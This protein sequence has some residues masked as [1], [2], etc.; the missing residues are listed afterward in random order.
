MFQIED[1]F[2]QA[3]TIQL[4]FEFGIGRALLR[5]L[6]QILKSVDPCL[7]LC[8]SRFG[9]L[10]HP[11]QFAFVEFQLL[12]IHFLLDGFTFTLLE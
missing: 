11:L 10:A 2:A 3:G 12:L 7:L 6:F 9:T 4:D 8:R 5:D 1:A